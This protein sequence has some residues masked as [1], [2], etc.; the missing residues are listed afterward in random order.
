M[1]EK[2]YLWG[3]QRGITICRFFVIAVFVMGMIYSL[4]IPIGQI[5]DEF[6]H[7]RLIE[8][9]FGIYGY[10]DELVEEYVQKAKIIGI[11]QNPEKKLELQAYFDSV[12]WKFSKEGKENNFFP[13]VKI[14]RHLPAGI[15][16][17]TGIFLNL[18]AFFCLQ[19]A[20]LCSL[21]FYMVIGVLTLKIMPVKRELMCA[22][23]LLPMTIQQC[24]SINYDAVLLPCCFLLTSMIFEYKYQRQRIGWKEILYLMILLIVISLIKV[25]YFLLILLFFVIP[26]EKIDLPFGNNKNLMYVFKKYR[27]ALIITVFIM[28]VVVLLLFPDTKFIKIIKASM[29]EIPTYCK[30]LYCTLIAYTPFYVESMIGIFGW[31]DTLM[32]PFFY[33]FVGV[34]LLILAL[35][36]NVK[37]RK[38]EKV[39]YFIVF[40]MISI[41][42]FTALI[43][44]SFLLADFDEMA[45]VKDYRGYLK[46]ITYIVGVQGR[47]FLPCVLLPFLMF[48]G[49]VKM[50]TKKLIIIQ[51]LYYTIVFIHPV[52]ILLQR[53]WMA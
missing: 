30:L 44:H 17:Y 51:I 3:N 26:Y 19:L 52:I 20:E 16:F 23:M 45:N 39:F 31:L 10:A 5:P 48:D 8:E 24:A 4:L 47:Y 7:L 35:G 21:V 37:I 15:G 14:V 1:N 22:I 42:I 43:S 6:A 13:S 29:L 2:I 38:N 27:I 9:E 49:I 36:G 32:P 40:A 18:P 41:L 25:P 34:I 28:G 50:D 11:A 33:V 12:T 46:N 53:Y